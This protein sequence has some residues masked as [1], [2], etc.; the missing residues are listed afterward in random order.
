MD[1]QKMLDLKLSVEMVN[2]LLAGLGKLPLEAALPVFTEIQKQANEQM[3]GP[4][5][6]AAE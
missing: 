3:N 5:A 4:A 2:V 6:S 1:N